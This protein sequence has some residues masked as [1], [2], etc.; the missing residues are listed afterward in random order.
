MIANVITLMEDNK[1]F[2][3]ATNLIAS[4]KKVKNNF[5]ITHFNAVTPDIVKRVME[6]YQLCLVQE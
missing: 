5:D 2:L 1:S 3:G 6:E 4:S